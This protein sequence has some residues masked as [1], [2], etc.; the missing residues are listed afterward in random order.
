MMFKPAQTDSKIYACFEEHDTLKFMSFLEQKENK[1]TFK[2]TNE[3]QGRKSKEF[4]F[5]QISFLNGKFVANR[6]CRNI[7]METQ[8]KKLLK[9]S[10]EEKAEL[11]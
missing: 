8:S 10:S 7:S 6:L 4:T 11:L 9:D 3:E 5:D 1:L 2:G